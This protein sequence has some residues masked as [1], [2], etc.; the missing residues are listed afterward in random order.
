MAA[1]KE[2]VTPLQHMLSV[3][4]SDAPVA[5]KDQMAIASAPYLHPKLNLSATSELN[6]AGRIASVVVVG[7]P[8][9]GQWIDG[10]IVYPDGLAV[11][12]PAFQPLEPTPALLTAPIEPAEPE[13]EPEVLEPLPVSEPVGDIT[14]L[15]AWRRRK[16][17]GEDGT[18][19]S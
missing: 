13:P 16:R 8:R 11:P 2:G 3:L 6:G 12:P 17:D 5:R 9:G 1:A 10:R 4:N 19:A 14:V 7:V 18:P 15:D